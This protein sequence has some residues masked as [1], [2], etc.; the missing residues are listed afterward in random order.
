MQIRK[1]HSGL[2]EQYRNDVDKKNL[3][4]P[5]NYDSVLTFLKKKYK[6][7]RKQQILDILNQA[8][9]KKLDDLS[10]LSKAIDM[11]EIKFTFK[12]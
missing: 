1:R 4:I 11:G 7:A 10:G 6:I 8:E 3:A 9:R 2:L 12:D 5:L